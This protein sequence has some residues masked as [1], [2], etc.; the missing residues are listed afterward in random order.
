MLIYIH[1]YIISDAYQGMFIL[2]FDF[3]GDKHFVNIYQNIF[4]KKQ[5]AGFIML[6]YGICIGN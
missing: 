2:L 5:K 4:S 1:V 3:Y 6:M